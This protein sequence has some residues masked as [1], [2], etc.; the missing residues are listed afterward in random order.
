MFKEKQQGCREGSAGEALPESLRPKWDLK[1]HIKMEGE[2]QLHQ[3]VL[4][5]H[6]VLVTLTQPLPHSTPLYTNNNELNF[7]KRAGE[8]VQNGGWTCYQ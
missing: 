3:F 1:M 7:K 5:S 8:G 6:I 4:W 2:N